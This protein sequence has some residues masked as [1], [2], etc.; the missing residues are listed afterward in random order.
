M[1]S[2]QEAN[3]NLKELDSLSKDEALAEFKAKI[4]IELDTRQRM[5]E[6]IRSLQGENEELQ[7][8]LLKQE[9][10]IE[11]TRLLY[12]NIELENFRLLKE[13]TDE[14]VNIPEQ[15]PGIY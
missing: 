14:T 15:S 6:N 5:L 7:L 13:V 10:T 1:F 12:K 4:E 8:N 11:S 2:E 9:Q 3:L